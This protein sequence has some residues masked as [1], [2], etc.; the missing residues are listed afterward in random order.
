MRGFFVLLAL[1]LASFFCFSSV[2]QTYATDY[3]EVKVTEKIP[4]ANCDWDPWNYTCNVEKWFW[5]VKWIMW[6]MIKYFT[7]IAWLLGI[8]FI[9]VYGIMISMWGMND[10]LKSQAKDKIVMTIVGLIVLL[11]SWVILNAVAPWIYTWT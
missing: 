11:L 1:F 8:L 6:S 3:I 10:S 7:F 2:N 9:V 5:T 4:W